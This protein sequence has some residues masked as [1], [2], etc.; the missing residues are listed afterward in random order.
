VA[1]PEQ[2]RSDGLQ[3]EDVFPLV[4]RC[5]KEAHSEVWRGSELDGLQLD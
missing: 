2:E 1:C 5:A 4:S 3:P